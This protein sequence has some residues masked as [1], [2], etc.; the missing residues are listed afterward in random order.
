[1]TAPPRWIRPPVRQL[2]AQPHIPPQ[3]VILER[4]K[5]DRLG[6]PVRLLL[7]VHPY[8]LQPLRRHHRLIDVAKRRSRQQPL[9]HRPG[10]PLIQRRDRSAPRGHR[11]LM[12]P[13]RMQPDRLVGPQIRAVAL[14]NRLAT[15]R[16][17][18]EPAEQ[19]HI[20]RVRRDAVRRPDSPATQLPEEPVQ[21]H[22]IAPVRAQHERQPVSRAGSV[23]HPARIRAQR[24]LGR[25]APLC[26]VQLHHFLARAEPPVVALDRST[27][28]LC[29]QH[30]L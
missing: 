1:M 4:D 20:P 28:Q 27:H 21:L 10:R 18:Q 26:E 8:P 7:D 11:D 16:R 19:H 14:P 9:I 30:P 25:P 24:P 15:P 6:L 2:A 29:H 12:F 13:R 3:Q 23:Q 17:V 22:V 5:P